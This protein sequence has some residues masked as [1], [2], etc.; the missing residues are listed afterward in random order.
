MNNERVIQIKGLFYK[1]EEKSTNAVH[2]CD[3]DELAVQIEK[4]FPTLAVSKAKRAVKRSANS[5]AYNEGYSKG[6]EDA[7]SDTKSV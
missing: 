6:Y 2:R 5:Y 7:L 3:Y 1:Y 4:L